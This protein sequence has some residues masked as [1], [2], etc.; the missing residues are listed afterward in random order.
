MHLIENAKKAFNECGIKERIVPIRGGTDGARLSFRNLPC[1]NLSA[2]G[3]NFHIL[4][5]VSCIQ[6][7]RLWLCNGVCKT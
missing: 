3:E 2:G 1:P 4:F 7:N 5:L 6:Q